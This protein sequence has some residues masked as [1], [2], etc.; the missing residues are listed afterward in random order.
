MEN[1]RHVL[2]AKSLARPTNVLAGVTSL[3]GERKGGIDFILCV[4]ALFLT[5]NCFSFLV[6]VSRSRFSDMS[7]GGQLHCVTGVKDGE[8]GE[9]A[10]GFG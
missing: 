8:A 1:C 2:L 10:R 3:L 6:L 5:L 9:E 7:G 4:L